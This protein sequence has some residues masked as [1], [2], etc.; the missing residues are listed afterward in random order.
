M[1]A[2]IARFDLMECEVAGAKDSGNLF[3]NGPDG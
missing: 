2:G 1:P 3:R